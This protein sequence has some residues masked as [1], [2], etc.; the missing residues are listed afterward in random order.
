[1]ITVLP[2]VLVESDIRRILS[3]SGSSHHDDD[4]GHIGSSFR[5]KKPYNMPW[6]AKLIESC[7]YH[8][9]L[10]E[11]DSNMQIYRLSGENSGVQLHT[12]EDF[13]GPN[14]KVARYSVLLKLNSE[15]TGGETKFRG[16]ANPSRTVRVGGGIVFSHDIPHE[17]LPVISGE[18]LVLKT[19]IFV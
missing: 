13:Y 2:I 4:G 6:L 18:K 19:D 12:D 9:H 5:A 3:L 14:G 10:G 16:V 8:L 11:V 1:M 15:Y 7:T 17:G